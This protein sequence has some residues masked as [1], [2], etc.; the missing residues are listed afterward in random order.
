MLVPDEMRK[1]AVFVGTQEQGAM[2][3]V[4]GTVF[5]VAREIAD[6]GL[7]YYCFITAKHV[8]QRIREAR[9]AKVMLRVNVTAGHA[10]WIETPIDEWTEHPDP[11]VDLAFY[12]FPNG[13]SRSIIMSCRFTCFDRRRCP[14][15]RDRDW[16]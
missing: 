8:V 4:R 10:R 14:G 16:R 15:A 5:A 3:R 7:V 1:C 12:A 11:T 9:L 13:T 2:P 6:T